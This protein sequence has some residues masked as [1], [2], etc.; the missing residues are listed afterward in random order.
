MQ[1][2]YSST[3]IA[4]RLWIHTALIFSAAVMVTAIVAATFTSIII[5]PAIAIL[6]LP[7]SITASLPVLVV[8]RLTLKKIAGTAY[9]VQVLLVENILISFIYGALISLFLC[10]VRN[11]E[12][13]EFLRTLCI[14][15]LLLFA[16][17]AIAVGIN[18]KPLNKFFFPMEDTLQSNTPGQEISSTQTNINMETNYHPKPVNAGNRILTKAGITGALI[19]VMLIPTVFIQNLVQERQQRQEEVVKEVSSKWASEQTISGPYIV[20]PYENVATGQKKNVILLPEELKVNG[21]INAVERARS[22]YKVLLYRSAVN[23]DGFFKI[24]LTKDIDIKN[25]KL[26]EARICVGVKDFKGIEE[27]LAINFNNV[28]YDLS[29]GLPSSE[30]DSTGL[31]ASIALVP[32]NFAQPL[33]FSANLKIRGSEQLHF[34]PLSANSSFTLQSSW[35]SPSFDG[36]RLPADYKISPNGFTATWKFNQANLPFSTLLL[37]G[38]GNKKDLSFGVS[39]VQPADQYAKTMRSAKYAILIIGLSFALFF[40]VELMQNKPVHPMQYILVGF[41]LVIFYTLLL[42]ISEFIL[43]DNAYIIAAG[44]TVLLITF[45]VQS[46]FKKWKTALVFTLVLS[47]LYAFIFVLISL[48]DTALLIGSIGLFIILALIMFASRKINWYNPSFK[49]VTNETA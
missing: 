29:P 48:E 43:F 12:P 38:I 34:M 5:V 45:Y 41:A 27:R 3:R 10:L 21:Q 6:A 1:T 37:N 7:V 47:A 2:E 13:G 17:S 30:I 24:N 49:T 18:L 32:E 39:M 16:I 9:P 14:A 44:A 20:I 28:N 4:L 36:Y 42:S 8:H 33:R 15:S 23:V 40:I 22:I 11:D 35:A 26:D 31:S 25:L 19:L 46:H